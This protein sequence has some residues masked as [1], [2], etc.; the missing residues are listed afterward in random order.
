MDA[1]YFI[2][3]IGLG[4]PAPG[5]SRPASAKYLVP[6]TAVCSYLG[7]ASLRFVSPPSHHPSSVASP[8]S[9]CTSFSFFPKHLSTLPPPSPSPSPRLAHS[10]SSIAPSRQRRLSLPASETSPPTPGAHQ[11]NLSVFPPTRPGCFP[12]PP[13]PGPSPSRSP[14]SPSPLPSGLPCPPCNGTFSRRGLGLA[15]AA[16]RPPV[17]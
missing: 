11:A 7:S 2:A 10:P 5:L 6:D 15:S 12:V 1:H 13:S 17:S 14:C 3:R 4:W 9:S 16:D 8:S